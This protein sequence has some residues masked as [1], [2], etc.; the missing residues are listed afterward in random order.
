MENRGVSF[1]FHKVQRPYYFGFVKQ[2]GFFIAEPEKALLDA[3][4]LDSLG[5]CPMDW[6]S[7]D[8]GALDKQKLAMIMEPFPNKVKN[9]IA[10]S[11]KI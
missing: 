2:N 3:A 1:R 5:I 6:S 11:C 10:K 8:P 7:L 4:Y 9:R